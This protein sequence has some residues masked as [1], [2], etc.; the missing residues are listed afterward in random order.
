MRLCHGGAYARQFL[1]N[2][3]VGQ[4]MPVIAGLD[5]VPKVVLIHGI[6]VCLD[7]IGRNPV[8]PIVQIPH[9]PAIQHF[10]DQVIPSA[11]AGII[12]IFTLPGL[13]R[14]IGQFRAG[15]SGGQFRRAIGQFRAR[16]RVFLT[17]AAARARR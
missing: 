15:S 9:H 13:R 5:V 12:P 10:P 16:R 4:G 2:Y 8:I 14:A 3:L 1:V 11:F 6:S 7:F 17:A